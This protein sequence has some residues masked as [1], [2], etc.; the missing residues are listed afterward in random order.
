MCVVFLFVFENK[1]EIL[2]I[3]FKS[4]GLCC[5]E[6]LAIKSKKRLLEC[7]SPYLVPVTLRRFVS[8]VVTF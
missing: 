5:M 2:L 3:S 4:V 6:M 8:E 1:N 7:A